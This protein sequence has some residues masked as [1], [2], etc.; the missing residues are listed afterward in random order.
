MKLIV[1]QTAAADVARLHAF[2]AD[3]NRAAA[4]RAVAALVAAMES[5]R[6]A[7]HSCDYA[8]A[9][10]LVRIS[11][12]EAAGDDPPPW[13]PVPQTLIKFTSIFERDRKARQCNQ[14]ASTSVRRRRP[15]KER[16][17][18]GTLAGEFKERRTLNVLIVDDNAFMRKIVRDLLSD[19]GV[20]HAIEAGD[21]IEALDA[22]RRT[23]PDLVI[24]DWDMP[25]LGGFQLVRI[26][27]TPGLFPFTDLPIIMLS[28]YGATRHVLEAE[29]LGVNE[30]L[31]K[32]VS[33]TALLARIASV[34][35][36]PRRMILTDGRYRPE[37]RRRPKPRLAAAAVQ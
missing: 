17:M 19:V 30:F 1:S 31:A 36:N 15:G 11:D 7:T 35:M 14:H 10:A 20:R 4:D 24:L 33:G 22:I 26:V 13:R 23:A 34:V 29:R 5:L 6:T 16:R 3:K 27:R 32:P 37:P 28:G 8:D 21:G 12:G 9:K 2:L 18:R 25:Y